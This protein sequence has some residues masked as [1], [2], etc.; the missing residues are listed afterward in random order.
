MLGGGAAQGACAAQVAAR[1][2]EGDGLSAFRQE[3]TFEFRRL[4][5]K[6]AKT[7]NVPTSQLQGSSAT[8]ACS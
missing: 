7:S 6:H 4:Y 3:T 2:R 8:T 1:R 5:S